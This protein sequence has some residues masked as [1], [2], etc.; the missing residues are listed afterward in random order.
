MLLS[1][2]SRGG[3]RARRRGAEAFLHYPLTFSYES[4]LPGDAPG[5][6]N[7][8]FQFS[9]KNLGKRKIAKIQ[10][11][12]EKEKIVVCSH[13]GQQESTSVR[14]VGSATLARATRV[15]AATPSV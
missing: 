7:A 12:D 3:P 11:S 10:K 15:F 14:G 9:I 13:A 2:E 1:L 8:I 5:G 6:K 4:E